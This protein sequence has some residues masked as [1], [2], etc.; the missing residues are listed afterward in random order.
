MKLDDDGAREWDLDADTWH[1]D[2]M[3]LLA[4]MSAM[5]WIVTSRPIKNDEV[6]ID[7]A[8]GYA[9]RHHYL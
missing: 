7:W 9:I 2:T 5:I 3:D 6:N 1:P 8:I 4:F